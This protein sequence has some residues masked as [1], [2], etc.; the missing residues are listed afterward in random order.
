VSA[1]LAAFFAIAAFLSLRERSLKYYPLEAS[2]M[3]VV[4]SLKRL[5]LGL[6][7]VVALIGYVW[8]ASVR[9]VPGVRRRKA[10]ARARRQ[11]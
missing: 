11:G 9:A 2:T 5:L 7:A 3:H 4:R 10:E 6:A 8:V 1:I